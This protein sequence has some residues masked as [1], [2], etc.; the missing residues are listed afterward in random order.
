M[1]LLLLFAFGC[2]GDDSISDASTGDATAD[3]G[4]GVTPPASASPPVLT[5]CASGWLEADVDGFTIC[6]PWADVTVPD[7]TDIAGG[8]AL[9]GQSACVS[10]GTPCPAGDFPEGLPAGATVHHVSASAA[11]G[12]DGSAGAPFA[13]IGAAM[14][15][16][17][18]DDVIA[19]AKG[20]YDEIVVARAGVTL[21]GACPAETVLTS[22]SPHRDDGVIVLGGNGIVVRNLSI[23]DG[24]RSGISTGSSN[25]GAMI[26]DVVID[27]AA[28]WGVYQD[29]GAL[30]LDGVALRNTGVA[31]LAVV[32]GEMDAGRL[33]IL[34]SGE[35]SV[36]A[37]GTSA[38]ARV[39][40]ATIRE[41][42]P[43]AGGDFGW[44][45]LAQGGA[46]IEATRVAI[47]DNHDAAVSAGPTGRIVL[48]DALV[49]R[50]A[51]RMFDDAWGRGISAQNGAVEVERVS[52]LD[53]H[54][55]AIHL[56]QPDSDSSL[57]DVFVA[58]ILPRM[59]GR[60]ARGLA[61]SN[62]A[63]AIVE[64]IAIVDGAETG[65]F[66]HGEGTE[67]TI[68][69][70]TV[71]DI[72]SQPSDQLWGRGMSA[73]QSAV[74]TVERA[75]IERCRD[76][77]LLARAGSTLVARDVAI[78]D[79]RSRALDLS[80]GRGV[81]VSLDATATI[82]R[83]EI[84][85]VREAGVLAAAGSTVQLCDLVIDTVLARDCAQSGCAD[86][87]ATYGMGLA[88]AAATID[89]T[90]FSI[91]DAHL[92]GAQIADEGA[93][94]L[95]VGTISGAEVGVCIQVDG[96]DIDRLT[97]QVEYVDNGANLE[98][99]SLPVPATGD[100]AP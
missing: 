63:T 16:A 77:G 22:S 19:I 40:D 45:L 25:A 82:E 30:S 42:R 70:V 99:T 23:R 87:P 29:A 72:E 68:S 12:G 86:G 6:E 5:P 78:H 21:W 90:R 15:V 83:A 60:G 3:G 52:V 80:Y 36:Y 74:L 100:A 92:C 96:Y 33:E 49:A 61:L 47:V 13:T 7:C 32:G 11:A 48:H 73:D 71:R 57:R 39:S 46:T 56:D 88:A 28:S 75:L 44:A 85:R 41:T 27:G 2:G 84:A 55:E 43:D 93:L 1:W 26:E 97:D 66:V 54:V 4:L 81:E 14:S 91:H 89:A 34:A 58:R 65:V 64:R 17:R 69:D 31:A 20:R 10:L 62:G 8:A 37:E 98:A 18:T 67:L 94:D 38:T 51:T 35:L 59:D 79:V 24:A 53:S 9:P 95:S 50:T 76:V